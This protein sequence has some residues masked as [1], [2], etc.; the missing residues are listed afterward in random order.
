MKE[1]NLN[2]FQGFDWNHG[3]QNKNWE[4]HGVTHI[5]CEQIFFNQPLLVADDK[6]H[7][8]LENRYYVLGKTNQ[9]RKLFVVFTPRGKLIRII[10]ARDMS[11]KERGIY[12][13][14]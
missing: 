7:S 8:D 11:K 5:E 10:S 12:E 6:N 9:D 2:Q 1:L 4:K 13:Q 3:N 14:L